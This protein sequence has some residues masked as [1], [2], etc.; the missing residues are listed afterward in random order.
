MLYNREKEVKYVRIAVC[1]D[2]IQY[3]NKVFEPIINEAVKLS[4]LNAEIKI[5]DNAYKLLD[6][7]ST[8]NIYDIVILDIDMPNMNGKQLAGKLRTIDS[9]FFLIFSTSYREEIYNTIQYRI[10]AF[11]TK[12]NKKEDSVAELV[13]VFAEYTK[14]NPKYELLEVIIDG[15]KTNAKILADDIFYFCCIKRINYLHTGNKCYELSEKRFIDIKNRSGSD[16]FEICRGF[17]VN[18]KKIQL[19]NRKEVVLDNGQ[20]LPLSRDKYKDLQK[21]L[22]DMISME[23]KK[24]GEYS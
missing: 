6:E 19:V 1:D 21:K 13:R 14:F 7:F 12:D 23:V 4:G 15:K 9:S 18:I 24:R 8:N 17:I 16:F 3:L 22:S 2:D 5:F 10:N 20:R 11:I